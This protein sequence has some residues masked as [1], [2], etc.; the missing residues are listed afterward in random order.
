VF[1]IQGMGGTP[2]DSRKFA[3]WLIKAA[4]QGGPD[5]INIMKQ[6]GLM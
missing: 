2:K 4:E 3:E 6:L 5:A 1:Y